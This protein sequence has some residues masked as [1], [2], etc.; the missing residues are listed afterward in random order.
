MI[1]FYMIPFTAKLYQ[2]L[3][4]TRFFFNIIKKLRLL[5]TFFCDQL[6]I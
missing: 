4:E 1:N 2:M 3:H 5:A 6:S